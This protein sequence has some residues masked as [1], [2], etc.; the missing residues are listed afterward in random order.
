MSA[1]VIIIV[2]LFAFGMLCLGYAAYTDRGRA[3]RVANEHM[4]EVEHE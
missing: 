2:C 1:T 4:R 3:Q